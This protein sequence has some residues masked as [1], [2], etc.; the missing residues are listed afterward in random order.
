MPRGVGVKR[1][2]NACDEIGQFLGVDKTQVHEAW[3][4]L[5]EAGLIAPL[6]VRAEEAKLRATEIINSPR[7]RKLVLRDPDD[8]ASGDTTTILSAKNINLA[9]WYI[10]KVGS[11]DTAERLLRVAAKA[12]REIEG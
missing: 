8:E 7:Q 10:K 12:I 4:D 9:F 1:H 2:W 3:S 5:K 11:V 6:Q